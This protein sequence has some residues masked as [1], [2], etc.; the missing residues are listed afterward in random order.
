MSHQDWKDV[1]IN[2]KQAKP[3]RDGVMASSNSIRKKDG[4]KNLSHGSTTKPSVIKKLDGDEITPLPT[5]SISLSQQIVNA[6]IKAGLNQKELAHR[7]NEKPDIVKSYEAGTAIP[8][9]N[10]I[11]KLQKTLNT[12]FNK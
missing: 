10:I 2:G 9:P 7:I 1:V 3:K 12:V 5:I 4:G 11:N 8:N 6:R